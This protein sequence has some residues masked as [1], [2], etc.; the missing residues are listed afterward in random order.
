MAYTQD[1]RWIG[2]TTPLGED[3]VL[4]TS[5]HGEEGIS[6]LF[7]F[8]L[9]MISEHESVDFDSIIGKNVTVWIVLADGSARYINGQVSRFSQGPRDADFTSYHAEI[10][11]WLWFLT[12]TADCRIFQN[13]KAPDIIQQIFSDF[14][15][16]DY[17]LRLYGSFA[18]RE[19]C[20]QYR[21]TAFNFISRLM[22]EEGIFY[23]FEHDNGKHTLVLADSPTVH[24][25]CPHQAN[26]SYEKSAGSFQEDDVVLDWRLEQELRP[27]KYS[28]TDY[29]FENPATDLSVN[30]AGKGDY[31]VYDFPGEYTKR[32]DGD[33][34]VRIRLQETATPAMIGHGASDCRAFASGYKFSLTNHYRGSQ[35]QAYIL[36]SIHHT[37]NQGAR[38]RSGSDQDFHYRN[39]FECI[40]A[41]TPFRPNRLTPEPVIQGAQTA[42]VVGPSGEEIFTD[43]YG[44]VKVQFHWDR[45]GKLDENSS[46]WIRVAQSW[47]G[48]KWGSMFI[49]RIGQEVIVDFLEGDPDRPIITGRVYNAGQMPPYTLP[50]EK[51]KSTVKSYSSMGGG[52]FNEIR[53]EDKKGSEQI[54]IHAEKN[55]DVRIKNDL[56]ETVGGHT[57][58]IVS[59]DQIEQVKGD[60]HQHVTG[61]LNEKIDATKSLN[62]AQDVQEKV[63]NNFAL[64]A[65]MEIYLKAGM[66]L[67]VESGTMMTLKVG[68]NFISLNPA[69]VFITGTMVMI[70]SGGSPGSGSGC[71][72]QSPK[73][74]TEADKADPGQS[75]TL[76]SPPRA[77]T[78]PKFYSPAAMVLKQAAQTGI[79]F[80]EH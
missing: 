9:E 34:R 52:G 67:V 20:V 19:Y 48:K 23:F 38:Y 31:E 70:N 59:Q 54:F 29:D 35:N 11:P 80:C 26:V 18:E 40:P 78:R 51:T 57:H 27:G 62:V 4:L 7:R 68:A 10:V 61:D 17:S 71:S 72:P 16:K 69:G 39:T 21:E 60:K 58:L 44:R 66:N 32:G 77:P 73:D 33:S 76:P 6:K 79:P 74:P 42:L 1:T 8:D 37:A 64:D 28:L 24:Q 56:F 2:V 43:K 15:F 47:A 65:G 63:G 3:F 36:T 75:S 12:R 5:F 13:K 45:E 50:D 49:P 53:F 14:G 55:Q 22:E 46:C 41:S 30:V 25:P